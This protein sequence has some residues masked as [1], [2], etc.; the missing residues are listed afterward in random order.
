VTINSKSFK[1]E[2][3]RNTDVCQICSVV[4]VRRKQ[5]IMLFKVGHVTD[6]TAVTLEIKTT[7]SYDV[8]GGLLWMAVKEKG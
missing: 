5:K 8:R 6:F 3:G 2:G 1:H 4:K 7:N